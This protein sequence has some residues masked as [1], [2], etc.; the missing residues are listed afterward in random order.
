M[1]QEDREKLQE[2]IDVILEL[3]KDYNTLKHLWSEDNAIKSVAELRRA[4]KKLS[5]HLKLD[6][7]KSVC[8]AEPGKYV[9]QTGEA[10]LV[11]IKPCGD[12]KTYVGVYLGDFALGA[13]YTIEG[14]ELIVK[15]TFNNPAIFVPDLKK[16]VFGCESW[17]R[18]IENIED[19]KEI[20]QEDIDNCWY[21]QLLKTLNSKK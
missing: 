13:S 2:S 18:S 9:W 4:V 3:T 21:M 17:W 11:E 12:E 15:P 7:V 8:Y 19:A 20:N 14:E 5:F 16:V 1:K 6:D 10:Q